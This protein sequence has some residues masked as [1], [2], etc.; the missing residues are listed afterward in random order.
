MNTLGYLWHM[1]A[2]RR[3]FNGYLDASIHVSLSLVSLVA[4]TRLTSGA[5]ISPVYYG[6]LF[7]GGIAGYNALKYGADPWKQY[8]LPGRKFRRIFVFSLLCL[9]GAAGFLAVL[10]PRYWVLLG[11]SGVLAAL[12]GLPLMPGFRNLRSF[13]W[14]KVPLVAA[15]WTALTVPVPLLGEAFAWR[16]DFGVESVQRFLWISILMLPFEIRDMRTDPPDLHTLPRLWGLPATRSVGWAACAVLVLMPALKDAPVT[17]DWV[18]STLAAAFCAW[19]V[20][21]SQPDRNRLFTAFWVESIPIAVYA[22]CRIGCWY[23]GC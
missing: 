20:F 9:G 5:G 21:R 19:A 10:P 17:S 22:G 1:G 15:V 3:I 18:G 23:Y 2:I 16:W 8:P 13:G 7:L 12:Y 11:L 14:I 6:A 4:Y